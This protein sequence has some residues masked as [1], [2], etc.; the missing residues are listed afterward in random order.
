MNY[1]IIGL[2]L[3]SFNLNAEKS[4]EK[5]LLW[6]IIF[7]LKGLPFNMLIINEYV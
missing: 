6:Y 1:K 3:V 2:W 5:D 4:L 7:N